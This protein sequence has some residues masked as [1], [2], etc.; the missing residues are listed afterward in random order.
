MSAAGGAAARGDAPFSRRGALIV[1][2]VGAASL[3]AAGLLGAFG[4]AISEPRSALSDAWSPSAVGHRAYL[5]LLR[6][7]GVPVIV[8]RHRT[9]DKAAGEAVVALLEPLVEESGD[10]PRASALVDIDAVARRL[11]VVLPKR[12]AI[13]DPLRPRWVQH[14]DVAPPAA[15]QRVLD[16][17][18]LEAEVVRPDHSVG[19][20][21]GPLPAPT[22]DR[23]QLVR[24]SALA[25]LVACDDGILAGELTG[26]GWRTIVLADPDVLETHGLGR[27]DDAVLAVRLAERLGAGARP[28]LVDETLHGNDLQPS[29]VRELLRFPL[30]LA[31]AQALLMAALLAWAALIRFGRPR[32]AAPLLAPGKA[33]LV[34]NTAELLRHGGHLSHAAAAYLKAAKDAVVAR[35]R[36]PGEAGE[37]D[38][39]LARLAAARGRSRDLLALEERV[40]RLEGARRGAEAETVRA[41]QAIH[42]WRQEMTDGAPG[43]PGHDRAAQG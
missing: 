20:W 19:A 28:L 11:L 12:G 33:F 16:L 38:A 18:D 10:G 15:A 43:D 22:L 6:D 5:A 26:D 27:G 4:D 14:A 25:P 1:A 8:S 37:P 29:L 24:S 7:L 31:T 2:G 21:R 23:P 34:E 42:R 17:L 32:P 39:W 13:P 36:P 35:L 41:A 9:A 40:R 3:L 30:V